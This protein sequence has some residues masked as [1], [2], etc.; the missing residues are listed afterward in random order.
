MTIRDLRTTVDRALRGEPI[1]RDTARAILSWP[2]EGLPDL[3]W[4]AFRVRARRWGRRVRLCV[5]Q[6][7]RSGLCPEDCHY[8]SQSSVSTAAIP[9]YRLLPVAELVAG[10]RRAVANGARRYCMVASGRGPSSRDLERVCEAARRIREEF[11]ELELCASLGLLDEA[12]ARELRAAGVGWVNHNLNTSERFYPKICTTHTYADRLRTVEAAR[13]A[14][15]SICCGG[16]LGMGETDEDVV[17]LAFALRQLRVDS[18]PV[19]F[20]HPIPGTPLGEARFLEAPKALKALCLFRFTN[21]DAD[22]R[23]AGGRERNLGAW[24]SL[25]LY[26]ANSIFIQGYLTTPGQAREEAERMIREMGF[27]IEEAPADPLRESAPPH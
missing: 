14:G 15:L 3:L 13:A 19:N 23:A 9:R 25:A 20:L 17:D 5:L 26:P 27:E 21:P 18:L 8:C 6:N 22:I 7:A 24:Q 1:E 10:A 11:P 4:A 16:I 2:D 12:Q